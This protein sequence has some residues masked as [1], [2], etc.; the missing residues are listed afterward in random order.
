MQFYSILLETGSISIVTKY[1]PR[2]T[3][4]FKF[5]WLLLLK[6]VNMIVGHPLLGDHHLRKKKNNKVLIFGYTTKQKNVNKCAT[7]IGYIID[8]I[9]A[10]NLY[11]DD[12]NSP[13]INI[14]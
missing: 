10:T 7:I 12:N 3:D 5:R 1:V 8:E 13:I 4:P 9:R 2:F 14:K 11:G 6:D